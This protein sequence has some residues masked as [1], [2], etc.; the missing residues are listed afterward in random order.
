MSYYLELPAVYLDLVQLLEEADVSD[1]LLINCDPELDET[2][3]PVNTNVFFEIATTGSDQIDSATITVTIAGVAAIVDGVIQS[4]FSGSITSPQADVLRVS[5][6]PASDFESKQE[7]DVEVE[8]STVSGLGS[9]TASY[10]FVVEDIVAP[11]LLAGEARDL[12]TVRITFDDD[13]KYELSSDPDDVLNPTNYTFT[14]L[15]SPAVGAEVEEVQIV[16]SKIFDLK[17]VTDMT[18]GGNYRLLISNV[19]NESGLSIGLGNV[20]DFTAYSPYVPTGREF[21]LWTMLPAINRTMDISGDLA[22]I[23]SVFQEVTDVLLANIDTFPDSWDY[24]LA[25]EQFVDVL[26]ADLGNPFTQNLTLKDRRRLISVLVPIYRQKGTFVGIV[27]V[28]RFFTGIEVTIRNFVQTGIFLGTSAL[29]VDF[30]L[31]PSRSFQTRAF[32]IV[33]DEEL[34]DAQ[35]TEIK[36]LGMYMKPVNTHLVAVHDPTTEDLFDHIELGAS[37]L[38]SDSTNGTWILHG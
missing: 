15:S 37:E 32:D 17:T 14:A 16:S 11:I 28:I 2:N 8:A 13:M 7:V 24:E 36:L 23:I 20:L 21:D 19:A 27:N 22:K 29:N 35:R 26:L 5:I 34:T 30:I 10:S 38:G 6:N 4:G 1:H 12:R 33:S 18:P 9:F 31:N 3:V 25:D